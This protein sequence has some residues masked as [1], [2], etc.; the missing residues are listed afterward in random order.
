MAKMVLKNAYVGI[1]GVNLSNWV[2]SITLNYTAEVIDNTCMGDATKV[3]VVGYKD[4]S[5][6]LEL[7]Q[8]YA[9]GA[10]DA[11]LFPLLGVDSFPVEVRADAGAVAATNPKFTGNAILT[12]YNPLSGSVGQV[13]STSPK[14]EGSGDLIRA[15]A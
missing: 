7:A 14:L 10:V 8:D 3:K 15:V 9:A 11:T 12:S 1:N 5:I 2:K 6:D 4:W 13:A